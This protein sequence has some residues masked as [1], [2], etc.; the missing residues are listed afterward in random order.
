M[1]KASVS[2]LIAGGF[3]LRGL[4]IHRDESKGNLPGA[5]QNRHQLW[6]QFHPEEYSSEGMAGSWYFAQ[7]LAATWRCQ[8]EV[9]ADI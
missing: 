9:F 8:W 3:A 1:R 6:I 7:K 4:R 5:D 2:L